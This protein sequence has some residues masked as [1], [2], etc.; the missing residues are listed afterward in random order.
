MEYYAYTALVI[1]TGAAGYRAACELKSR[2][3][4]VALITEGV[5][6]GTS[7]NTG[8]DKQTYYKLSLAGD[9]PD[10]PDQMAADL[11]AGG[12]VDGDTAL[13]EA[14]GS[15]ACFLYLAQLGVA[16]PTDRYGR[17]VGYKT[18]HDPRARATS[19]GPLTSQYMTQALQAEAEKLQIPVYDGYYAARLLVE[20]GKILGV[21]CLHGEENALFACASCVLATGGPAGM[22]AD[23]VY[24][25][26]HTGSTGLAVRAGAVLQ[27]L[28]FWQY[29]LASTQPRWNVSGTYM[30]VLP[31]LVSVDADGGEHEFL[32]DHFETPEDACSQLFLKGYQWPFDPK[33]AENGSSRIDLWV[34][35]ETV[36]KGRKVYLDYTKNPR[37][38]ELSRLSPEAYGYLEKAGALFG[39]PL[40]RLMKMNAPAV[41]L[42]KSK[43]VDLAKEYLPIALCAQHCN[44]GIAVDSWWQTSVA[45]LFAIGECAGTHGMTRPG[46]SALNAGQV[47]AVRAAR[48][49]AAHSGKLPDR[50]AVAALAAPVAD[51]AC[52]EEMAVYR[53]AASEAAGAVR[54]REKIDRF[55]QVA[56]KMLRNALPLRLEELLL[57]QGAVLKAM[58]NANTDPGLVQEVFWNGR[59]FVSRLRPV[60]PL[61]REEDC[62]ETVWRS[63]R[64]TGNVY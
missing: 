47:G 61:P 41:A 25:V 64:E 44:G 43:G 2:G 51:T 17:F 42:Y 20:K 9:A 26:G 11:F 38:L 14:A 27:N 7:R 8:S 62:F 40:D 5:N 33:K 60:R 46:G 58:Q 57:T 18:D 15:A 35:E 48:Y 13:C 19:A 1:G 16:F 63:Y 29:G 4:E 52:G 45:G 39:T 31:R 21:Q 22:Y 34:Y 10:S 28:E 50:E 30:Q 12:C 24:P 6:C 53:Q 49:I 56:Q 59:E 55:Q 32:L 3:V 37:G 23:T 54:D 36:E